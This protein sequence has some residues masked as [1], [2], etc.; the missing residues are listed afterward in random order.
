MPI[1]ILGPAGGRS[2][3]TTGFAQ[4]ADRRDA[5]AS[6]PPNGAHWRPCIGA[7]LSPGRALARRVELAQRELRG[8]LRR[9]GIA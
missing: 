3:T 9:R 7:L 4:A 6:E 1:F 2:H 5:N 8:L